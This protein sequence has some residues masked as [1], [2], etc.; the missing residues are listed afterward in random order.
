MSAAAPS[1]LFAEVVSTKDEDKLGRVQV[2]LLGYGAEIQMPWL[3]TIQSMA[4]NKFGG[5]VLPEVGDEVAVFC[6]AGRE[7]D[8]MVIL[9]SLYNSAMLPLTPDADGKNNIKQF[10]T[11]TKHSLTLDDTDGAEAISVV[12]SGEKIS[13]KMVV[14]D[15]LL[16]VEADKDINVTTEG[17]VTVDAKG[18]VTIKTAEK[19][20]VDVKAVEITASGDVSVTG[21]KVTVEG[22]TVEVSSSGTCTVKASG[23][24]AVSGKP[25][26]LG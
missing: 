24:V 18:T 5:F 21:N 13:L 15:G 2:K 1:L 17:N 23:E 7:P 11:R 20:V 4:S 25:V 6:G 8:G 12:A 26:K 3:R 22:K 16:A 10:V 9:G 14:A 19:V